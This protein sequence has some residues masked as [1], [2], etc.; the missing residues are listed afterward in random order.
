MATQQIQ[1]SFP[2]TH[3]A[4]WTR[5]PSLV[6]DH[7]MLRFIV[8][9]IQARERDDGPGG[10]Y[11]RIPLLGQARRGALCNAALTSGQE[12]V[13][14]TRTTPLAPSLSVT[15]VTLSI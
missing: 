15:R 11:P 2:A 7:H 4:V 5:K 14:S 8:W 12:R 10:K 1:A 9:F 6:G 13:R 3:L